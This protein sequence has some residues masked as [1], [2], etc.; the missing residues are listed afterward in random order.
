MGNTYYKLYVQCVFAVKYRNAVIH[1]SWRPDLMRVIGNLINETGCTNMIVNGVEDHVHCLFHMKP[2]HEISDIMQAVKAKS[3]KWV[4]ENGILQERFEW[5]K[6]D[7][8][9]SY[10]A[11]DKNKIFNYILNQEK[12]HE[13]QKFSKEYQILLDKHEVEYDENYLFDELI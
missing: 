3:S 4:N 10:S 8:A 12:H 2:T 6:G 13:K 9:F 5:Q 11:W 1:P 7:G